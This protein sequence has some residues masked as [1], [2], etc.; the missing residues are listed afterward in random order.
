MY[1]LNR[2]FMTNRKFY[3]LYLNNNYGFIGYSSCPNKLLKIVLKKD[4]NMNIWYDTCMVIAEEIDGKMYDVITNMEIVKSCDG[5]FD[6]LSY[7]FANQM[8]KKDVCSCL[9]DLSF[10]DADRYKNALLKVCD[11][12]KK[13][14]QESILRK[15]KCSSFKEEEDKMM[16]RI[17][18]KYKVR[19]KKL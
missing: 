10:D 8:S 13:H 19:N 17:I 16:E 1:L 15:S 6:G 7:S 12:S 18:D 4:K 11:D 14:Y 3:N 9:K 2:S 5:I